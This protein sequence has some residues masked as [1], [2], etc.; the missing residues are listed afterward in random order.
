[1]FIHRQQLS[2]IAFELLGIGNFP[3]LSPD[4]YSIPHLQADEPTFLTLAQEFPLQ[5][6]LLSE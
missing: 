3:H 4:V 6:S 5:R 2:V 1:M